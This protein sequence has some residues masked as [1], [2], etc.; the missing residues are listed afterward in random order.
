[1]KKYPLFCLMVAV[2]LSACGGGGAGQ[3]N[4]Q[5]PEQEEAI[6]DVQKIARDLCGCL[7]EMAWD[8]IEPSQRNNQAVG[9]EM[10]KFFGCSMALRS[11]YNVDAMDGNEVTAEMDKRC[12]DLQHKMDEL[13]K[14]MGGNLLQ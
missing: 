3:K 12:P 8:K 14:R 1:M 10:T 2:C 13:K 6:T 5:E 4:V 9:E 11:K 7:G